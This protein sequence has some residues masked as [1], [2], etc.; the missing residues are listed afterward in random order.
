MGKNKYNTKFDEIFPKVIVGLIIFLA[1]IWVGQNVYL[2]FGSRTP[3]FNFTNTKPPSDV[4][5]DFSPFWDVWQ[6]VSNSYLDKSKIDPQKLLYGAISGMVKAVGDPYTVFL[7]PAQNKAFTDT[8]S[9][10]YQGVG[11]ELGAKKGKLVVISPLQGTPAEKAGVRA[12]DV[13]LGIDDKDTTDLTVPEA[14]QLIRGKAGTKIKLLI[15]RQ[16]RTPFEVTMTRAS[17]TVKSV[18]LA[19]KGGVPVVTLSRFGDSTNTEWDSVANKILTGNYN[20]MILDLR[21]DP[22][23]RLDQAIY[24]AGEFLPKGS[25]VLIQE[26]ANGKKTPVTS[27]REGQLQDIKLVI[28]VNEGSASAAEIV[29]GALRDDNGIK[30]VGVKTFGKGTVQQVEDLADGSGLHITEDKW[31]TPNGTWVNEKGL[32]PDFSVKLTDADFNA[33]RD[34]QLAKA[35]VLIR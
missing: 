29:S 8:L 4:T 7:D 2:P 12:G 27:S 1:G 35:L 19:L 3:I 30:L 21:N 28:L 15:Q 25:T 18:T 31:L 34:P 13:I 14:V 20:K 17:I 32:S 11:I 24:V 26:D 5:V 9:G 22:G 23:G 16:G 10:T 33:G 6:K